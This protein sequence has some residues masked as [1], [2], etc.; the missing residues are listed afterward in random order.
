MSLSPTLSGAIT[1]SLKYSDDNIPAGTAET[2]L[3]M[4]HYTGGVWKTEDS[5]TVDTVNNKV[6]CTVTSLSPF[7]IGG[8]GSGA[9]SSS[10]SS[11]GGG[12]NNCDSN[13]FG[14]GR[15]LMVYN[16]NYSID[17]NLVTLQAYSTCGAIFAK[18]TTESGSQVMGLLMEQPLIDEIIVVYSATLHED[19]EDFTI[20]VHNKKNTFDEKY[21]P[22]GNDITKSYTGE[23][24][25][26]P[27]QQGISE[28]S[29]TDTPITDTPIIIPS[30]P[31]ESAIEI[32]PEIIEEI[33]DIKTEKPI[34]DE[35]SITPVEQTIAYT[36]E[37]TSLTCGPGTFEKNGICVMDNDSIKT[38]QESV[39][40]G[41]ENDFVILIIVLPA[42]VILAII[43]LAKRR[44]KSDS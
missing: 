28:T 3:T 11:G 41:L 37:P 5:C 30:E 25:Y 23:M 19:V 26:T 24:G 18:I 27:A 7:G 8:P 34:I 21:Y 17:T 4:L 42:V 12:G 32:T 22:H 9:S 2:D 6:T 35:K 10:S 15:S 1:I 14:T 33:N 39:S 29:I 43:I 44:K 13:G 38:P 40:G 31:V 36:P 20:N 16:V